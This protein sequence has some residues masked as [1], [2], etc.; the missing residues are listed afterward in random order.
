MK[1]CERVVIIVA[2][3]TLV[4]RIAAAGSLSKVWDFNTGDVAG[5]GTSASS[6]PLGVFAL[7]FS[8]DGEH[9]VAVVGRSRREEFILALGASAP[10]TN[11]KRLDIN[12]QIWELDPYMYDRLSW[13]T[14]GQHLVLGRMIVNL[15]NGNVCSLPE[16]DGFFFVGPSEVV[17]RELKTKTTIRLSFF[18]L[19]CHG[20]H[21]LDLG[22]GWDLYD[23][24]AERGLLCL[25]Q[26]S[27]TGVYAQQVVSIMDAGTNK[28]LR[29]LPLP[30]AETAPSVTMQRF[31][32]NGK[33]VCGV[34]GRDWRRTVRCEDVDTGREIGAA[35]GYTALDVRTALR[36]KRAILSDYGR[37]LDGDLQWVE[38]SL[39]KR[40]VWDFGTGKELVSWRPKSQTLY[41]GE[42]RPYSDTGPYR[43]AIS[44]DGEYVVEGGA[45]T[46]SLYK[47]EP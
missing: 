11:R 22:S 42:P 20:T 25:W 43:F 8:P 45:G 21:T 44:P 31:A 1:S 18:D 41:S 3:V 13:S 39:K 40:A 28:I 35:K 15:S 9:I 47:I 2:V 12:P 16:G 10:Q 46:L 27:Y 29:R 17:G 24:S 14:S 4:G 6:V 26:F 32:D 38:G 5:T 37:K 7:S 30:P 19:D 34:G 23:A 33:A 36:A